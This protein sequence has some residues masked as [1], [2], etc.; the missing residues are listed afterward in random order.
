[1]YI[2]DILLRMNKLIRY[3]IFL[4]LSYIDFF[5]IS[6]L[7][8]LKKEILHETSFLNFITLIFVY[9]MHSCYLTFM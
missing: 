8:R 5:L 4:F 3:N 7:T 6:A 2:F 1:M 9:V